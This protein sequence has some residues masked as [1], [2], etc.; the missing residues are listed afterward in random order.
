MRK[1][2]TLL[3]CAVG[4]V[5]S[6]VSYT[7]PMLVV[8]NG[9][10]TVESATTLDITDDNGDG[11]YDLAI[12]NFIFTM[13]DTT[14]PMGTI[15]VKNI[16][17]VQNIYGTYLDGEGLKATFSDGNLESVPLWMWTIFAPEGI[18]DVEISGII[19]EDAVELELEMSLMTVDSSTG[20]PLEL[21]IEVFIGDAIINVMDD[22][23]A[24]CFDEPLALDMGTAIIPQGNAEIYM[25]PIDV[26]DEEEDEDV[27]YFNLE[28]KNFI[29][30]IDE[31]VMPF[32]NVYVE[33]LKTIDQED[34]VNAIPTQK[35][36]ATVSAGDMEG[37]S[38]WLATYYN[39]LEVTIEGTV[40][41][42]YMD[43]VISLNVPTV[44]DLVVFYGKN[45]IEAAG[46]GSVVADDDA[47][48][49][50]YDLRGIRVDNPKAG[51]IY[52]KRQGSKASKV[53]A[54]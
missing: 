41:A 13:G 24:F 22:D 32:G 14:V 48:V 43:A 29:A 6:A 50:L 26:E 9:V 54:Q 11:L 34:G 37:V 17:G 16:P 8:L 1:I 31:S 35:L 46:I 36:T 7:K 51:Q 4:L 21:E 28:L 42:I 3:A 44:G 5:A 12:P 20:Q 15:T 25:T 27:E 2:F 53:L 38:D 49:E 19:G 23:F 47:A 10:P 30:T 40:S 39:T 52:I 33:N 45:I 18:D